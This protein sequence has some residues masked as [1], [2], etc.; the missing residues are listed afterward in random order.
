M[1][2]TYRLGLTG[3]PLAHSLSPRLH[4]AAL[5]ACGLSGEYELYPIPPLPKGL[6]GL[7][8]LLERLRQGEITGL[9]VTIPHKQ[10]VLP[11][12]DMLTFST[13]AIGAANTLYRSDGRLVGEN[14]DA[15]AFIEYLEQQ[16]N[17]SKPGRALVLGAGGAARA[18][19][20]ALGCRGWQVI[21]AARRPEQVEKLVNKFAHLS[22]APIAMAQ[23]LPE[24]AKIMS[25]ADLNLV[26]NATPLGMQPY[27]QDSPWPEGI[28]LPSGCLV[29]DLIYSPPETRLLQQARRQGNPAIGGLGMLV[30]QAALAFLIWTDLPMQDLPA[31]LRAMHAAI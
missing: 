31:V 13:Q 2:T 12:L 8:A 18:C 14:T 15:P 17:G 21:L 23:P 7:A 4:R 22:P 27:E 25:K 28:S 11:L 5:Q 1:S 16:F 6:A 3:W 9:N 29:Y 10:A 24:A 26:V 20:Y 19:V 30:H